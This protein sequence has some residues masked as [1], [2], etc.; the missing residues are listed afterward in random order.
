MN[1]TDRGVFLISAAAIEGLLVGIGFGVGWLIDRYPLADFRPT[2]PS[3]WLGILGA[4][5]LWIVFAVSYRF[6]VGP[7]GKLKR[8][9]MELL[10][11]PLA[12]C[13]WYDLILLAVLV[14]F[15]EEMLFRGVLQPWFESAGRTAG[16]L[17]TNALFGLAHAVTPFYAALAGSMGMYLSLLLDAGEPRNI[18]I[19]MVTHAVYDYGAFLVVAGAYRRQH[20]ATDEGD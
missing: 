9:I 2:L 17:G 8:I 7:F 5:P 4:I 6:P 13:R 3:V 11:P 19:P 14:G 16:L 18:V 1:L 12:S 15:S 20:P 10:G